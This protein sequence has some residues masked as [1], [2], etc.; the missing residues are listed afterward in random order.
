[1]STAKYLT[2]VENLD[3]EARLLQIPRQKIQLI[4]SSKYFNSGQIRA[5]HSQ[6]QRE[7]GEN[8]LQDA[9]IKIKELS[10]LDL[11][12]HFFGH[13]QTNK[14]KKIVEHFDV[15]HSLD[16]LRLARLLNQSAEELQKSLS[17]FLQVNLGMEEQK[18]GYSREI[19]EKE[20]PELLQLSH[21]KVLGLMLITP[22]FDNP[23]EAEPFFADLAELQKDLIKRFSHPLSA[24]SM[25]M[26]GDWKYA[27]RHGAT[28]LRVGRTLLDS[29]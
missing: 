18:S 13:I 1:M 26:S 6:G 21:L 10:D 28:H 12:W 3:V 9:L 16:S 25:G 17:V 14:V 23:A 8:R 20:F 4:V 29:N 5:L 27:L 19:L 24:L 15:V 22:Y 11:H 2:F 7:F